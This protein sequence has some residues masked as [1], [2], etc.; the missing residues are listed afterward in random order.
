[1]QRRYWRWLWIWV[2]VLVAGCGQVWSS[3]GAPPQTRDPTLPL[4]GYTLLPPTL[5]PAI[6]PNHTA[7]PFVTVDGSVIV[8]PGVLFLAVSPP[9]CYETP[10]GSLVCLGQV[11]NTLDMPIEHVIVG[12]Q[13]L[14]P[15]GIPLV[16]GQTA[17][18]RT[19]IPAGLAGPYRVLFEEVPEDYAGAYAFIEAGQ[20]AQDVERRY[21][22]LALSDMA[23]D[24]TSEQVEVTLTVH[25]DS[26]AQVEQITVT[27]TLLDDGGQVTGF[28]QVALDDNRRLEPGESLDLAIKVIPQGATT[29]AFDAFVEGYLSPN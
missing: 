18:A 29:A 12:V 25:N 8:S 22:S 28:R 14:A 23:G 4:F 6:R 3:D 5:T 20:V 9:A 27:V 13:L 26:P 1:M 10:V 19:L 7:T 24:F 16:T 11:H 21:A 2:G 17:A 15:D